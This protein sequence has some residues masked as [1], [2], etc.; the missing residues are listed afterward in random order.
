MVQPDRRY[1]NDRNAVRSD[2]ER[3]FVGAVDRAAV[4]DD[5]QP[6]GG[7]LVYDAVIEQDDAIRDVFFE[8]VPGQRAIAAFTGDYGG[9]PSLLQPFEQPP[10][11][12]TKNCRIREASEERLQG[13]QHDTLRADGVDSEAQPD[14]QPLEV[15]AARFLDFASHHAYVIDQQLLA[16]GERF[17]V[18]PH[19]RDVLR[20]VVGALFERNENAWFAVLL[21][22]ANKKL[23]R[24]HGFPATGAAANQGSASFG[25]AA[26]GYFV[27]ALNAGRRL[28][29]QPRRLR[30]VD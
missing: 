30:A 10:D 28:G 15:V 13:V 29:Q 16:R 22:A 25:Q 1:R 8:S 11:F 7:K 21:R 14:E 24:E 17:E 23:H 9:H 6:P 12:R 3:I 20:E 19:R 4:F 27:Q 2:Q 26:S 18:E 5:P